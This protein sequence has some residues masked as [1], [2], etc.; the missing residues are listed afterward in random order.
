MLPTPPQVLRGTVPLTG[1]WTLVVRRFRDGREETW[2]AAELTYGPYG[3]D[4]PV[5]VVAASTDPA[6]LPP[7]T[8]R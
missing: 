2:W 1:D 5:R 8:T 3:P 4:K 7:L 6:T